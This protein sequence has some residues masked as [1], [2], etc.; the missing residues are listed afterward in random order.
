MT[1]RNPEE[2]TPLDW[3]RIAVERHYTY[4]EIG[5]MWQMHRK[6]LAAYSTGRPAS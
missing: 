4:G 5:K 6:P 2:S 3:V 1:R